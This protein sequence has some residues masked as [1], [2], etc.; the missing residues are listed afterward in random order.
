MAK[1]ECD[2]SEMGVLHYRERIW[3][4][5]YEPLTTAVINKTR[6]S[7]LSGH[8]GRNSNI[9]LILG[10]IFWPGYNQDVRRF[11]KNYDVCGRL[12]IQGDK[13]KGLLRTLLVPCQVLQEI[14]MEFITGITPSDPQAISVFL[15]INDRLSKGIILIHVVSDL[16]DAE[17]LA[18]IFIKHYLPQH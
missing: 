18:K 6:D 15:V 4:P 5:N 14:S 12:N 2:I 17:G 8:P 10:Q 11:I 16:F 3:L 1:G 9:S 7:F 13:K